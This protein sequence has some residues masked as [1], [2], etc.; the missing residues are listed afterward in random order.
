[1]SAPDPSR[2]DF[3]AK[4]RQL[5]RFVDVL[6]VIRD[7]K[8]STFEGIFAGHDHHLNIFLTDAKEIRFVTF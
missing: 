8:G 1:M 4:F 7:K 5:M 6:V 3:D 2:P